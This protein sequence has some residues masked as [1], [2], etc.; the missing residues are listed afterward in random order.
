MAIA[1]LANTAL[2][3]TTFPTVTRISGDPSKAAA[4]H[5][6]GMRSPDADTVLLR[7]VTDVHSF[8]TR[9]MIDSMAS[10]D[11]AECHRDYELHRTNTLPRTYG[12]GVE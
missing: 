10:K 3:D 1:V 4:M 7:G 2:C 9:V 5:E 12:A 8:L 11:T 6:I